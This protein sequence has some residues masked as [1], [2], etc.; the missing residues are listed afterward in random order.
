[1]ESLD[2]E[3]SANKHKIKFELE[4]L[5]EEINKH[6]V[7]YPVRVHGSVGGGLGGMHYFLGGKKGLSQFHALVNC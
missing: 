5:V 6:I 7:D 2:G 3:L 4:I 1:M